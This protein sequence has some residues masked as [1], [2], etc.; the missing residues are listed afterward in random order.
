MG[1]KKVRADQLVVL[2]GLAESRERAR[3]LIMAGHVVMGKD[4]SAVDRVAKPGSLLLEDTP[5]SLIRQE[6]FVSR[7]GNKLLTALEAFSLEVKGWVALD[8]GASTGGFTDCLLQMGAVRVYA[9]DVGYGQLHWKLRQDSRVIVLERVNIRHARKDLL[10]EPVD[11]TVVDCSF[12][13]LSKV[14]HVCAG[15]TRSGGMVIALIKPQFELDRG[16]TDKGVVRSA[17]MQQ[18]AVKGVLEWARE[19]GCFEELGVV[20]SRITGPKG[21]QEYLALWRIKAQPQAAL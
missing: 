21:N 11:L 19:A 1:R 3:R 10:P 12:I 20:P 8:V 13:S 5:L 4:G 17:R 9:L 16:A 14:L 15:F 18:A 2:Q 7:G 6:R